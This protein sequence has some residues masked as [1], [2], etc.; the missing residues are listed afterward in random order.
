MTWTWVSKHKTQTQWAVITNLWQQRFFLSPIIS[1]RTCK[2]IKQFDTCRAIWFSLNGDLFQPKKEAKHKALWQ[3]NMLLKHYITFLALGKL[4]CR[5]ERCVPQR[6][7]RE[8]PV[9]WETR[10]KL[11]TWRWDLRGCRPFA[12]IIDPF[13]IKRNDDGNFA[14]AHK[15]GYP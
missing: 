9:S 14:A 11:E 15:P 3:W 10:P 5:Y 2:H 6:T 4:P 13:L 12:M 1:I 7:Y 8:L